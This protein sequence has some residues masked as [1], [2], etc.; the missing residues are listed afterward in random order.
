MS[1]MTSRD[2]ASFLTVAAFLLAALVSWALD[3][4]PLAIGLASVTAG[5]TLASVLG[6]YRGRRRGSGQQTT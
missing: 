5:F 1:T 4:G 3:F 6:L 2:R